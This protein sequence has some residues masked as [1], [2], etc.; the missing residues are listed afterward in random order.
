MPRRKIT[1]I[2]DARY[3]PYTANIYYRSDYKEYAV[4]FFKAGAIM[5][6]CGY[7]TDDRDDAIG[8]ATVELAR[9]SG[10]IREV[11]KL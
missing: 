4:V 9:M 3:A 7:Y 6:G 1:E 8:T 11:G 10:A 5:L 2:K